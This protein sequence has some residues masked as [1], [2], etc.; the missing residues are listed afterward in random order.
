MFVIC[1]EDCVK[2]KLSI[3]KGEIKKAMIIKL[4]NECNIYKK[5]CCVT[6]KKLC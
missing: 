6:E 2:T 1:I 3:N 4:S 5:N